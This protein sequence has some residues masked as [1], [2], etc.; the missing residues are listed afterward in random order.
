MPGCETITV[1]A[2]EKFKI[3]VYREENVLTYGPDQEVEH[4]LYQSARNLTADQIIDTICD[5]P[6]IVTVDVLYS[7]GGIRFSPDR[8]SRLKGVP[9]GSLDNLGK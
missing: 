2:N 4:L 6:R 8:N 5:L 1:W 9:N 3:T 7:G